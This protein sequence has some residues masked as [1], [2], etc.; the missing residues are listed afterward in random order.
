M[1]DTGKFSPKQVSTCDGASVWTIGW[2]RTGPDLDREAFNEPYPILREYRLTDGKMV[3][4]ALE[5]TTFA[6]WPPPAFSGHDFPDLTMRCSGKVLGIYEGASDEWIEYNLSTS[7]LRRWQLPKQDHPSAE[8][9]KDGNILPKPIGTRLSGIAMLDSGDVYARFVHVQHMADRYQKSVGLY[10][11]EKASDHG[12]WIEIEAQLVPSTSQV[13]LTPCMAQTVRIWFTHALANTVGSSRPRRSR[14][15][16]SEPIWLFSNA[17]ENRR[18]G[19]IRG[20]VDDLP[21]SERLCVC[22]D[23]LPLTRARS[24]VLVHYV[25]GEIFLWH[26]SHKPVSRE[27]HGPLRR[28]ADYT[29]I[30]P[31]RGDP[32]EL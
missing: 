22:P 8:Q 5:R 1:V 25:V 6:R 7:R 23:R 13:V 28:F 17:H 30:S 10:R 12:D 3:N 24:Q 20:T 4:S 11:L 21:P 16:D 27:L 29:S 14:T 2:L 19:A 31:S 32:D 15:D 18:N 9:D 26:M